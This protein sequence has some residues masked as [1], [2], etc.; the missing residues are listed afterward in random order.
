MPCLNFKSL[1]FVPIGIEASAG[2]ANLK[3]DNLGAWK[4]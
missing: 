1:A 3:F 4:S 2:K